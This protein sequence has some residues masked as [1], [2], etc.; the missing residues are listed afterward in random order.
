MVYSGNV[1]AAPAVCGNSNDGIGDSDGFRE[2]IQSVDVSQKPTDCYLLKKS[3]IVQQLSFLQAN[4]DTDIKRRK[5]KIDTVNGVVVLK[6]QASIDAI[7]AQV[8]AQIAENTARNNEVISNDLCSASDLASIK[9]R[10][11]SARSIAHGQ[12]VTARAAAHTAADGINANSIAAVEGGFND[13]ADRLY[14]SNDVLI[15]KLY[16]GFDKIVSCVFSKR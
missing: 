13:F 3:N 10:I 7:D 8:A 12:V 2:F 16:D 5:L 15:D 6:S 9:S 1:Y 4:A 11:A 14:N